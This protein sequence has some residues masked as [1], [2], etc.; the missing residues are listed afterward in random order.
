MAE[1]G[2]SKKQH[3]VIRHAY[4]G[5]LTGMAR[6]QSFSTGNLSSAD[7]DVRDR[8][9]QLAAEDLVHFAIHGRRLIEAT[10]TRAIAKDVEILLL[11]IGVGRALTVWDFLNAIIHYTDIQ[12]LC[13]DHEVR[14]RRGE[15]RTLEEM[16]LS[17][18]FT[19]QVAPLCILTTDKGRSHAF[20]LWRAVPAFECV[21]ERIVEYCEQQD[22]FLSG[23]YK[24]D[25]DK[26]SMA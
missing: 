12:F 21:L 16:L 3:P 6:L 24:E 22:L 19:E 11:G 9:R 18:N 25:H 15:R 26:F 4:H 20:E 14:F 23:W 8:Q 17:E 5:V 7:T 2:L 10:K 1:A 13:Y